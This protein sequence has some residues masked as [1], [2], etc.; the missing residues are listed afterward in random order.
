MQYLGAAHHPTCEGLGQPRNLQQLLI[1]PGLNMEKESNAEQMAMQI[2]VVVHGDKFILLDVVP[3]DTIAEVKKKVWQQ[4]KDDFFGK[5][6]Y[7]VTKLEDAKTLADYNI[8]SGA[9]LFDSRWQ[10]IIKTKTDVTFKLIVFP[11]FFEKNIKRRI[12]DYTGI[13]LE[14]QKLA[15]RFAGLDDDTMNTLHFEDGEIVWLDNDPTDFVYEKVSWYALELEEKKVP[16][17]DKEISRRLRMLVA[18]HLEDGPTN[19]VD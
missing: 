12:R 8:R 6:T 14:D 11:D 15:G 5:L 17:Y 10:I 3:S 2:A 18:E 1:F 19:R 13:A 4:A 7:G 9:L 16:A